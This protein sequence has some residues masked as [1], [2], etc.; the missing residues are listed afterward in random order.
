MRC[1]A[2]QSA[3]GRLR[4]DLRW[5]VVIVARASH[6]LL[7]LEVLDAQ[8]QPADVWDCLTDIMRKPR[9]AEAHRPARIE[10]RQKAFHAAWKAKLKQ[11]KVECV[12]SDTLDVIDTLPD[13]LPGTIAEEGPEGLAS[14]NPEELLAL[15]YEPGD[16]WQADIRPMPGWI[17]GE[18]QPYR[19]WLAMVVSR[20][21]DLVLAHQL[22]PERPPAEWLWEAILQAVQRPAMGDPHR[23]GVIE[24]ASV[25]QREA[26]L[27]HLDRASI[28]CVVLK[29]LE[30]LDA[31]LDS[32]AEFLL[33]QGALPSLLDVPGMEPSQVGSFYAA[34]AEFYRRKPWQQVPGDTPIKVECDKFHSGPWYAVVMGQSGVQ[35]GLAVYE[36]LAA[37]QGMITGSHSEEEN[38]A[39]D[40]G[41]VVNV[42][43]AV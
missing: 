24:V 23:P 1:R 28:E 32:M 42:Q 33:G 19:P 15:P 40:V 4:K 11:I 37:L 38:C 7:C 18:G 39:R 27:P 29:R 20:T 10:V 30:H 2:G 31:A 16:V 8:P 41:P 35:Q 5:T 34:A 36:D 25:G 3:A 43:R 26:L 13:H 6:E 14:E 17:T 22:A 21:D 9:Q 12:L